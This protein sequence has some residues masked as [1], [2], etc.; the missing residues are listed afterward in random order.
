MNIFVVT[1]IILYF[2]WLA[3]TYMCEYV[4]TYSTFHWNRFVSIQ[5]NRNTKH[6]SAY[7]TASLPQ[8]FSFSYRV[9]IYALIF[10][11]SSTFGGILIIINENAFQFQSHFNLKG[12]RAS[13]MIHLYWEAY[14]HRSS[15]PIWYGQSYVTWSYFMRSI[16]FLCFAF[17]IE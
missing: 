5:Y 9:C 1:A 10:E 8:W 4:C 16:C 2:G 17:R 12:S 13:N 11:M 6:E 15:N 14:A 3:F 7:T